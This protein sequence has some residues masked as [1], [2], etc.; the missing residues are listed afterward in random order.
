MSTTRQ[1]IHVDALPVVVYRALLD[2][3]VIAQYRVPDGMRA[4]VHAF[5]P[6][7]G[8]AFRVSLTYEAPTA[9]GKTT[10]HTDTY[11][12]HFASLVPNE[13]VVERLQFE[14]SD[15]KLQGEMQITTD[16]L[17]EGG[18]TRVVV[19]HDGVPEAVTP[20]DNERGW[21]DSLARLAALLAPR[22]SPQG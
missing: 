5:E 2:P 8:G 16:L 1:E 22:P 19:V 13:R 10:A 9:A 20:A 18:G 21:R 7:E 6:W 3:D 12:G 4:E 17:P 14:T 11:A 15:P